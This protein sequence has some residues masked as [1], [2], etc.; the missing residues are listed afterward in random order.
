MEGKSILESVSM[1]EKVNSVGLCYSNPAY[2]QEGP[3]FLTGPG[4]T[5]GYWVLEMF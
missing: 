2:Y 3:V 4:S 1:M 5:P